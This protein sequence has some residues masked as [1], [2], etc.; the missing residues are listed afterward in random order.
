MIC[1]GSISIWHAWQICYAGASDPGKYGENLRVPFWI[2]RVPP[3]IIDNH[4]GIWSENNMALMATIF[5]LHRPITIKE[6]T[7]YGRETLEKVVPATAKPR[8]LPAAL[9]LKHQDLYR[10]TQ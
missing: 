5:R 10:S 7:K 8:T 1:L 9:D 4:G 3:Q 6:V 2:V